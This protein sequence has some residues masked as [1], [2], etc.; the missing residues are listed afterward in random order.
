MMDLIERTSVDMFLAVS[1]AVASGNNLV[2]SRWPFRI[3]PNFI[4]ETPCT[5]SDDFS[6]YLTQLP[7]Q[8]YLL[9]VGALARVKGVEVL[10]RAYAELTNA[11]PLVLIG[12]QSPDWQQLAPACPQNVF[13]LKNWP[14]DAVMQA[15]KRSSIALVP[16][17]WHEPCPTVAM[18]AMSMGKPVIATRMGGLTDI[19]ADG[20]TGVLVPPNNPQALRDAIQSLL[21]APQQQELMGNKAK[22]RIVMFQ[23]KSVVPRIEQVYCDI[24]HKPLLLEH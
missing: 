14:H 22:Q 16:S 12:Y 9:F 1:Q 8:N 5:P 23:A 17:I 4:A 19:V 21:D 6:S 24:L 2:N 15:W 13:I 20:E 18:E 10:L 11:P 3:I 7:A